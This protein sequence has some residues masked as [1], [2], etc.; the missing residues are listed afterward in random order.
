M[1]AINIPKKNIPENIEPTDILFN[2]SLASLY[3]LREIILI[4]VNQKFLKAGLIHESTD[5]KKD[6]K[7]YIQRYNNDLSNYNNIKYQNDITLALK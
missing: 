3:R 5:L 7:I 2:N 4:I 6:V 1:F